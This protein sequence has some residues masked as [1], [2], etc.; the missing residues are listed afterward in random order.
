M[1]HRAVW[2]TNNGALTGGSSATGW[3]GIATGYLYKPSGG[4]IYINTSSSYIL[5]AGT[6]TWIAIE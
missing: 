1:R 5:E 3:D 4:N 6:Y 2:S